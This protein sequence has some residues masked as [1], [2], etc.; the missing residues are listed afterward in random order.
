[1]VDKTNT[2]V[3]T[4]PF[5]S[6]VSLGNFKSVVDQ[7]VDLA[8]LTLLVG[9][10]SSGKS[11]VLQALRLVQQAVRTQNTSVYFPLN[12][13]SILM[14]TIDEIR[15]IGAKKS[16]PVSIGIQGRCGDIILNWK[17][18]F[19]GV[20]AG[21]PGFTHLK[22]L[23][24]ETQ[25]VNRDV[26]TIL[27]LQRNR[28][29]PEYQFL[30]FPYYST[31]FPTVDT[32]NPAFVDLS[33]KGKLEQ[34]NTRKISIS[35][36]KL[37]GFFPTHLATKY[38]AKL[39]KLALAQTWLRRYGG[40]FMQLQYKLNP[41]V[42]A[43]EQPIINTRQELIKFATASINDY[44]TQIKLSEFSL[45][46]FLE[47]VSY[48]PPSLFSL[49][50]GEPL[51]SI[52]FEGIVGEKEEADKRLREQYMSNTII[53]QKIASNLN[54][55]DNINVIFWDKFN[56]VEPKWYGD[57]WL[58]NISLSEDEDIPDGLAPDE[59]GSAHFHYIMDKI[60]YLGPLRRAPSIIMLSSPGSAGGIGQEGEFT[61]SVL[62][63][64]G[65]NI[66]YK[67]PAPDGIEPELS[68]AEA[69]GK[70]VS[71]LG[72]A[73]DIS[74]ED[75]AGLGITMKVKP[76]GVK[77]KISLP[78]VGVGVSQLLPVLVLCLLAEP[79]SVILLEQPE[80]HLHPALQQKLADFFIAVAK[81]GRQLI[82]ETHS[83]YFI[84][85]LRRRV[86]EDADDELL[87]LVKIV[88]AERDPETG[89]TQYRD[90]DL[91]PYGEIEDWPK[92]FFDQAAEDE[93]E[94]I[95]G[96]LKKRKDRRP[97]E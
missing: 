37:S 89:E 62:R 77:S 75:L 29:K 76:S 36:V 58:E 73:D 17:A 86:V 57:H 34:I 92:G 38:S 66:I 40:L 60:C 74:A 6:R 51:S 85:R 4:D 2:P 80:L 30:T 84:S 59:V 55:K 3:N 12:G 32:R 97:R 68:L 44:F 43:T 48:P 72:L 22:S 83:E 93:R 61:A 15:T 28:N 16:A 31:V 7:E 24:I 95:R 14:G 52:E 94:I 46:H 1:M 87:E 18:S 50:V 54:I 78:S 10:N 70:W 64:R 25:D 41:K 49:L 5:I 19:S 79:G 69:V 13:D 90:L 96:A 33:I 91:T 8:R 20:V 53:A 9:E 88:S 21:E 63:Y 27:S 42:S 81:S 23:Q 26:K 65:N 82:V 47:N 67:V 35:G 71:H 39:A 11:S 56:D 45:D